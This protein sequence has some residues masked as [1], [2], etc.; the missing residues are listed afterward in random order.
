MSRSAAVRGRESR[1]RAVSESR[2]GS[3]KLTSTCD[4][5]EMCDSSDSGLV[6]ECEGPN[7]LSKRKGLIDR[8]AGDLILE[9]D[10]A[11]LQV[12]HNVV[13]EPDGLE[14]L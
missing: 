2:E 4:L 11:I 6:R 8:A 14:T 3:R 10:A 9:R 5:L 12:V 13:D 1:A 7:G